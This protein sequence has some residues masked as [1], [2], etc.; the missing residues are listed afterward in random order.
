MGVVAKKKMQRTT[1]YLAK[2]VLGLIE[3]VADS[4]AIERSAALNLIITSLLRSDIRTVDSLVSE[5]TKS[6]R[7]F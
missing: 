6:R 1:L 3:H 4:R 7:Q 5:F 2:E